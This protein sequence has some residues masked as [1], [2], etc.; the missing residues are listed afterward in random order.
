MNLDKKHP[1]YLDL[2]FRIRENPKEFIAIVGAGLSRPA[3]LPTWSELRDI[4]VKNAY[5]RESEIPEGELAG[6]KAKLKRI[7]SQNNLWTCFT[8]LKSLLPQLAYEE[9]IKQELQLKDRQSVPESYDLLWNLN[10][11]GIVTYNI[12]TCAVDSYA[13]IN[14][15]DVDSATGREKARF[16]QFLVSPNPF[17]SKHFDIT[18]NKDTCKRLT[19]S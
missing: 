5:S 17:V 15:C 10:I 18:Y 19:P 11:K 2:K 13:K 16:A 6:Y 14:R 4:L 1:E 9:C 8:E 12:D 7:A 3:G